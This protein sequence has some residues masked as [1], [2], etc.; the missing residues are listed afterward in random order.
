MIK[1]K[2]SCSV[3]KGDTKREGYLETSLRGESFEGNN[4]G[5]WNEIMG[6]WKV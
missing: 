4:L 1:L 3:N 5:A 2:V 6:S